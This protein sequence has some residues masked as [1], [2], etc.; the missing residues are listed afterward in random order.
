MEEAEVARDDELVDEVDPNPGL[1]GEVRVGRYDVRL[2]L[3]VSI[4]EELEDDVRVVEG[5]ALVSES[6]D[7]SFR[8]EGYTLVVRAGG[9]E[10]PSEG[11]RDEMRDLLWSLTQQGGVLVER[12]GLDVFVRYPAFLE[13]HPAFMRER[14]KLLGNECLR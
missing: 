5:S 10:I 9:T 1:S 11:V 8:I 7:Q 4:F 2:V 13:S 12:V 3:R 14:A 6:G